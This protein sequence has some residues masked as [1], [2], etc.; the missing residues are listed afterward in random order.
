M[1]VE[2]ASERRLAERRR[3]W[4]FGGL[5][6][7]TS[8][9]VSFILVELCGFGG[10]QLLVRW[11]S[12]R[13]RWRLVHHSVK[14]SLREEAEYW[15]IWTSIIYNP[16]REDIKTMDKTTQRFLP[17]CPL[18]YFSSSQCL[19]YYVSY[20]ARMHTLSLLASSAELHPS[21]SLTADR[22]PRKTSG[23]SAHR[24]VE[25]SCALSDDLISKWAKSKNLR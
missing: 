2:M 22:S 13:G 20:T 18:F 8:V 21:S 7:H 12:S 17:S 1:A 16:R 10:W 9:A 3:V 11:R 14:I 24:S 4:T 6:V 19:D 15:N 5:V 23:S 25:S